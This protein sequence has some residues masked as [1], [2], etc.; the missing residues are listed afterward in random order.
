MALSLP[1]ESSLDTSLKH[2]LREELTDSKESYKCDSC[3]QQSTAKI[4]HELSQLPNI[5]V[6]H[7]KRFLSFPKIQKIKGKCKYPD[8]IDM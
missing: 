1:F 4:I 6:F 8:N 2:F 7:L 5:I 3:K